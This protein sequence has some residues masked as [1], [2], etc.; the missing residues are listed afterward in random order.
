M[1]PSPL[2]TSRCRRRSSISSR[3]CSGE[4][5]LSYLFITHDPAVARQMADRVYVLQDGRVVEH[6]PAD[7]V[8]SRPQHPDTRRLLRP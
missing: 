8:L 6:G 3:D 2:W 1:N 7:D 4:R 5:G